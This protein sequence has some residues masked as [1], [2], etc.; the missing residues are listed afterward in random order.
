MSFVLKRTLLVALVLALLSGAAAWQSRHWAEETLRQALFGEATLL[1][2]HAA[3]SLQGID[4]TLKEIVSRVEE[5]WRQGKPPGPFHDAM[6]QRHFGDL[7]QVNGLLIMNAEG[8]L[9]STQVSE[10]MQ[11]LV[12]SER[13]YFRAHREDFDPGRL[14]VGEPLR[15]R[16]S[17]ASYFAA[18]YGLRDPQGGFGGV[19]VAVFDP[20]YYRRYYQR[21][22]AGVARR[23]VALVDDSGRILA[24]SPDFPVAVGVPLGPEGFAKAYKEDIDKAELMRIRLPESGDA[25]LAVMLKVP[26]LQMYGFIGLRESVALRDWERLVMGLAAAC[27]LALLGAAGAFTGIW[28]RETARRQA[29]EA[30]AQ[31]NRDASEARDRAEAASAAKSRFLAHISHELRTPLNAI[32]G[33]S[34]VIRDALLGNDRARDREYAA[35]IHQSGGHLLQIINDILDLSRIESGRMALQPSLLELQPLFESAE[36]LT[37]GDFRERNVLLEIA[38]PM[39]GPLLY[40]DERAVKQMLVNLLSNAAKFSDS[41]D[42]VRLSATQHSDASLEISVKDQ[43]TGMPEELLARVFEPF[44]QAQG[45][46]TSQGHGTGLGLPLVRSLI[47]LHGG[48]IRIDS[49][50]GQGTVVTLSFPPAPSERQARPETPEEPPRVSAAGD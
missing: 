31:A 28:W 43:G 24:S 19:A 9:V 2:E 32:L 33:F 27:L 37:R 41:G 15:S 23:D 12:D 36:L 45:M 18:S 13:D 14:F 10:L 3:R 4:L 39:A 35:L 38:P 17:S 1:S 20:F 40:A 49:H 42:L 25:H 48:R 29:F 50:E 6:L 7:P 30:L 5:A 8:R 34:E 26:D 11:S 21:F 46:T 47:E 22:E 44:S 16:T